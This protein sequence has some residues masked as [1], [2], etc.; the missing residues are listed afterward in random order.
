MANLMLVSLSGSEQGKTYIFDK[1]AVLIGMDKSC[2][3]RIADGEN[4]ERLQN[5]PIAEILRK[6]Y[7]FQL[8]RLDNEKFFCPLPAEL[9]R[10]S[11]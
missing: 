2:D 6:P 1:E 3:L 9:Q 7:G 4:S 11:R 5:G 8:S 10:R